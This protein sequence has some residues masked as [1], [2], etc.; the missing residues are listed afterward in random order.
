MYYFSAIANWRG[1]ES[2]KRHK[3]YIKALENSGIKIILG[4][5]KQKKTHPCKDNKKSINCNC[6][7]DRKKLI[8]NEEKNY[9]SLL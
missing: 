4:E 9:V 2:A 3:I 7:P 8:R 5:F 1:I 6:T